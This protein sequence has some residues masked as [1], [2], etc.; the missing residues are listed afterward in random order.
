VAG[1]NACLVTSQA[2]AP[3]GPGRTRVRV[4]VELPARGLLRVPTPLLRA[5]VRRDLAAA[6]EE[7]GGDLEQRG[8]IPQAATKSV[9]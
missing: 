6:L 1:S 8:Y 3:D 2:F 7:D 9:T 5:G 4:R